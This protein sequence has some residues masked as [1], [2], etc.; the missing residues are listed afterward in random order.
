MSVQTPQ[1]RASDY[2]SRHS[3]HDTT[4][5][6][7][8][9]AD[10]PYWLG[11]IVLFAFVFE[12][13]CR[14]EDWVMYRMPIGSPYRS[15]EDLIVRDADGR[16]GRPNAQFE[17]WVM[18]DLGTRGPA[19]AV[20]PS[21]ET[22]RIITVGASETF[23]L[24][25]SPNHEY[26]RQLEESLTVRRARERCNDSSATRNARFEVLNAAFAGMTV[27]TID[28]DVRNR[29]RRFHPAIVVAYPSPVAYLENSQPVASQPDSTA[30]STT[31]EPMRG[32]YPRSVDRVREQLKQILPEF[33]K[34]RLRQRQTDRVTRAHESNWQFTAVPADRLAAFDDDLRHLVGS[35]R[36]VGATPVLVTHGNAFFGRKTFDANALVAWEK[37]FP[38]ATGQTLISFDSLARLI[39]LKVGTDSAVTV[40]D[41][42]TRLSAAPANAFADAVHF[43][44]LGASTIASAVTDGLFSAMARTG[45]CR[46]TCCATL[47][48]TAEA[49][50]RGR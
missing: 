12:L 43:T 21:P 36:S 18:N 22:V 17:K 11:L 37:T 9:W 45:S 6:P 29:L 16:H 35:I 15:V 33:V 23:G 1:P 25:E 24:R 46:V 4:A 3:R 13:T 8:R 42:A 39:T 20:V 7:T 50:R 38:R 28:Q 40:V 26:P 44:D 31:A 30:G 10:S 2:T 14:V 27:P 49:V 19:A 5:S 34:T 48:S 32:L 47:N 41:A